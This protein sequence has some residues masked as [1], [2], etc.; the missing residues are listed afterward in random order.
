MLQENVRLGTFSCN[1]ESTVFTTRQLRR[2]KAYQ[3]RNQ[4]LC[5]HFGT[6][7]TAGDES[8]TDEHATT[9][10]TETDD[11]VTTPFSN[12]QRLDATLYPPLF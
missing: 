3:E 10:D 5:R 11:S 12:P 2:A 8:K 9:T 1:D 7:S 6:E 4:F